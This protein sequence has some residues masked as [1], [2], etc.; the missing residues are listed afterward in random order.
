VTDS[1][2]APR[3]PALFFGRDA[4]LERLATHLARVRLAVVYGVGGV[5]K[6]SLLLRAAERLGAERELP[7]LYVECREGETAST[8]ARTAL[9]Q[10]D[11]ESAE[12][13]AVEKLVRVGG[14]V[15]VLDDAHLADPVGIAEVAEYLVTRSDRIHVC[16]GSRS[17]LPL[18]PVTVDHLVLKLGGLGEDDARALWSALEELYGARHATL[19][20][21]GGNPLLIKRA[22]AEAEAAS[23][24][25]G[26]SSLDP[27]AREI[28]IELAA[29]RQ[30]GTLAWLNEGRDGDAVAHALAT[31]ERGFLVEPGAHGT[32]RVHAL[33]REAV[34][35]SQHAPDAKVHARCM[36]AYRD[37]PATEPRLI[38]LIHHAARANDD[39]A[40]LQLLQAESAQLRRIPPGSTVLDREIADAIDR[41][42][43][44]RELPLELR[45]LRVR[46]R[47]R[48][49]QTVRAWEELEA[50]PDTLAT[51]SDRAELAHMLGRFEDSQKAAQQVLDNPAA[52]PVEVVLA[53]AYL[54]EAERAL[55]R[56]EAMEESLSQ[57]RLDGL[58]PLA[59]GVRAWLRAV[60]AMDAERYADAMADVGQARAELLAVLPASAL[61]L[62][63]S[64]ERTI[65]VHV[66]SEIPL[67][68][69]AG[70]LFDDSA[71]F[72]CVARL[73]RAEE[74]LVLGRFSRALEIA[75][76][77]IAL[78]E[79]LSSIGITSFA[80]WIWAEAALGIGEID[81]VLSRTPA[82]I[83]ISRRA[84][85]VPPLLRL[86]LALAQ[87]MRLEGNIE[88]ARELAKSVAARSEAY[89]R[90]RVRASLIAGDDLSL[91]L[92]GFAS[93]EHEVLRSESALERG[94]RAPALQHASRGLADSTRFGWSELAVRASLVIA[95][96][97]L[98]N[99]NVTEVETILERA[100][101]VIEQ[102]AFGLARIHAAA[103]RAGLARAV[104][105]VDAGSTLESLTTF[106][107]MGDRER[108]FSRS[109]FE[110]VCR[111]L[112]LDVAARFFVKVD[113]RPLHLAHEPPATGKEL[114][115]DV[116][117]GR[118]RLF[119]REIDLS[120]KKSSLELLVAF[121]LST[122]WSSPAELAQNAWQ[123]DYH[124]VRHH[125]RLAMAV[126]RLRELIGSDFIESGRDGYRFKPP[127][128]WLLITLRN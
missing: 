89:P 43:Q 115:I 102:G 42:E 1:T 33:I 31:L 107:G 69:E 87:A 44:R 80:A 36:Q 121:A 23:D 19:D 39:D 88:G 38:E 114:V 20:A 35:H 7:V 6:T 101:P 104:G 52:S 62:L 120:R 66:G 98:S 117:R 93:T 60:I 53:I 94:E 82:Y 81:R 67:P 106:L 61:P 54:A 63:D 119:D 15:L 76:Q 111:R 18:S 2:R 85:H 100:R 78:G 75:E 46:V 103:L 68:E 25:L 21:S 90:V 70:E 128:S 97:E 26:L 127:P 84:S 29:L 83:E 110:R 34:L 13:A 72:R 16:I 116:P 91:P 71:Y 86:E 73:L 99:A 57:A 37:P 11:L 30:P 92:S 112:G 9:A 109:L 41:L 118:A 28:L 56:F 113:G 74:H 48:Q 105:E 124:A 22:F 8:M 77:N 47:G 5:G 125:S 59:S 10:L 17:T 27:L 4:E 64:L 24:P 49:G 32:I 50:L 58:G 96:C 51:A 40:L 122:G 55:G 65:R 12:G 123:L 3:S 14:F 79:S 45:L 95:E 126:A 108:D